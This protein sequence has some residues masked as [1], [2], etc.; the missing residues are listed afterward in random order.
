MTERDLNGVP[1][2]DT[3][4]SQI[5][6]N[7]FVR[8]DLPAPVGI[9][10]LTDRPVGDSGI[11][12][13]IDGGAQT[14]NE[15]DVIVESLD[16]ASQDFLSVSGISF[17]N[18]NPLSALG[19]R[20]WRSLD[21]LV[22]ADGTTGLL[23]KIV[24]VWAGYFDWLAGTFTGGPKIFRGKIDARRYQL[25]AELSLRPGT[26]QRIAPY[27]TAKMLGA[28]SIMPDPGTVIFLD[29]TPIRLT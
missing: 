24:H 8:I 12:L 11:S 25:R 3:Q 5:D 22:F 20:T 28:A 17:Q 13:S 7:H 21:G 15:A 9:V 29:N 23:G 6:W 26:A 10:R 1:V 4:K 19:D 27:M 18:I 14:W 16:Q 2:A